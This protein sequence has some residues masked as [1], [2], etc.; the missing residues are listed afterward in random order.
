[1]TSI[2]VSVKLDFS[3][4]SAFSPIYIIVLDKNSCADHMCNGEKACPHLYAPEIP[5]HR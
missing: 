1:M 2:N 3:V 5:A 4:Y